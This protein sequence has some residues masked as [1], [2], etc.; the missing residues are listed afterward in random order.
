MLPAPN[1]EIIHEFIVQCGYN[2][3]DSVPNDVVAISTLLTRSVY[4]SGDVES[5]P[6]QNRSRLR[7]IR[8]ATT[9]TT[10]TSSTSRKSWLVWR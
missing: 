8:Y 3:D 5:G 6:F 2:S 9:T 4:F 7:C 1:G 10:T